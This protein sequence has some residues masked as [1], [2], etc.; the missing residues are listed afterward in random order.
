MKGT[1]VKPIY[2]VSTHMTFVE[3]QNLWVLVQGVFGKGGVGQ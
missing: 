3:T 1:G 2:Y